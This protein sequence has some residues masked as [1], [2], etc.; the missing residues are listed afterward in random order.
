MS[1]REH[2]RA[3]LNSYSII[4]FSDKVFFAIIILAITFLEPFSG[5][6]GLI[7]LI[8]ANIT[9]DLLGFDRF[10]IKKGYYGF[11]SLLLGIGISIGLEANWILVLF[12]ILSSIFC[13]FIT[14][15]LENFLTKYSLP[16]LSLPFLFSFWLLS[17]A[18]KEVNL[19]Q[20][21]N[22]DIYFINY[23]YQLG[24]KELLDK[25]LWI[26]SFEIVESIRI[27]F[28]SLGSIIFFPHK[29]FAG[30]LI[31][32][33]LL[34][35]SR[36]S[37]TLS[38]IGYYSVYYFFKLIGLNYPELIFAYVGFNFILTAIAIG[39][40]FMIPSV[41]TY[42]WSI[43]L[44]PVTAIIFL[45]TNRIF[46]IWGLIVYSLPFIVTVLLFLL[47]VKSRFYRS[48]KLSE[49]YI[50]MNSPEIN[51][52]NFVN[53]NHRYRNQVYYSIRLPFYGEWVVSQS[54]N[55]KITHKDKW[56]YAY[57]FVI[58][59]SDRKT[60]NNQGLALEDYYCYDKAV[61]APADG[62]VEEIVDGIPDNPIGKIN[63]EEN[64][65]N[66]IIIRH[67]EGFYSQISHLKPGSFKV[68]KG[69][70]VKGGQVIASCGNSGRS[71]EPHIHFQ[72]QTL[73]V[74][75]A[76]TIDYPFGIYLS[77]VN[78]Q[79]KYNSYERPRKNEIVFN[80]EVNEFMKSSF[81]LYPQK[82]L[83][84]VVEEKGRKKKVEWEV[85][86]DIYNVSYIYC[87][88]TNSYAYFTNDNKVF[89]FYNFIGSKKSLLYYFFLAFYKVPLGFYNHLQV[90]DTIAIHHIYNK[91]GLFLQDF[92]AQAHIFLKADYLLYYLSVNDEISPTSIIL[93]SEIIKSFFNKETKKYSF[94]IEVS[95]K[96]I[97]YFKINFK[98]KTYIANC[99][100]EEKSL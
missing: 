64:W 92:I 84:F 9:A 42:I 33:G 13:F 6:C 1:I 25:Y 10:S 41:S 96:G 54:H 70:Y 15:G 52:Y 47:V 5:L 28:S 58:I 20:L 100:T 66:S 90:N 88:K 69:A 37:F 77:R 31:A 72:L 65:G 94:D 45:A 56:R 83:Q 59:D 19:I 27:Y 29:V 57:D 78:N 73:P 76:E 2:I 44:T 51:L 82:K 91:A 60:F 95:N 16:Y 32:I 86:T 22:R 99:L 75:G 12:I 11:N 93:K 39:G 35:Y 36:I 43:V 68:Q 48:A 61:L 81:N 53:N 30:F 89:Y 24:G 63:I 67:G 49:V 98:N 71:P 38:L 87:K 74:V 46:S 3:V 50:Q 85:F 79:I 14:I 18:I 26:R 34:F 8:T 7:A 62:Y 97:C 4:F 40:Y 55:G 80:L 21:A 23:V 17:L